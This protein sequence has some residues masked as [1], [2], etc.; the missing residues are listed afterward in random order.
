MT[1][2]DALLE[3]LIAAGPSA[4]RTLARLLDANDDAVRLRAAAELAKL[5]QA[6]GEQ[7]NILDRLDALE[8]RP[9]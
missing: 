4:V 1:D 6:A 8:E 7:L 3:D 5:A 9:L 2:H